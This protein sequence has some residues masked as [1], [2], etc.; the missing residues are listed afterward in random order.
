MTIKELSALSGYSVGTVSRV[1]ND[2]PN[3]SRKAKEKILSVVAQTGYI[4]NETAR[5][6][7]QQHRRELAV[8][9]RGTGNSLFQM[10]VSQLEQQAQALGC[11][12]RAF[13]LDEQEN[14]VA[15][16]AQLCAEQKSR[17]ILFLGSN[18]AHFLKGFQQLQVPCVLVTASAKE[19]GFGNLGSVCLDDFGAAREAVN[20]LIALGHRRFAI[21]GGNPW[22]SDPARLRLD[23]A[24][25]ALRALG[26][27][28]AEECYRIA[29]FSMEGGYEAARE[30]FS[31]RKRPTALLAQ[32]DLMAVGAIRALTELGLRV[33][34]DVSVMGFDGLPIGKYY[35]PKLSTVNQP[36]E[37]L[38]ARSLELLLE[39]LSGKPARHEILPFTVSCHES[40]QAIERSE[41][42]A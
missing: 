21:I 5:H 39:M 9:V 15:F 19:L 34:Q 42:D 35:V 37:A 2:Q 30:L 36:G 33:P 28:V 4:P 14:E 25:S 32:S 7:K 40:V 38:A 8:V 27:P 11:P 20:A 22:D 31:G 10:M 16:A 18:R 13:Y 17:G 23:G 12:L 6:L 24:M 3:V 26:E 1:L 29:R 41:H